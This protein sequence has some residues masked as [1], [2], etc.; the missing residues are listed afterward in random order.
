MDAMTQFLSGEIELP[1]STKRAIQQRLHKR[2][3][4]QKILLKRAAA[5]PSFLSSLGKALPPAIATAGTVA[6]IGALGS[7]IAKKY[8]GYSQAIQKARSFRN[9]VKA[10][11]DLEE[12]GADRLK[13][14]FDTLHRFSPTIAQDPILSSGWIRR[15]NQFTIEGKDFITP[16][17]VRDLVSIESGVA[18]RATSEIPQLAARS[19]GEYLKEQFKS[20]KPK[21]RGDDDDDGGSRGGRKKKN[22]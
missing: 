14:Q 6:L 21:G 13:N 22:K 7:S 15:V 17:V 4:I 9:M 11:P 3:S 2:A 19:A 10:Y 8:E 12:Y 18:G 16:D 20:K 5:R 1:H